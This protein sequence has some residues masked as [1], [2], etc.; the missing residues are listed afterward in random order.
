MQ[1]QR[2]Q[3]LDQHIDRHTLIE[4]RHQRSGID[5]FHRAQDPNR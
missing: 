5:E 2:T 4:P 1:G 3:C